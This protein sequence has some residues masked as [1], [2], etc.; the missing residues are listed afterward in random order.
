[1]D[2]QKNSAS[3]C[4]GQK[5]GRRNGSFL[6]I[7]RTWN[8]TP[9]EKWFE[10]RSGLP[11]SLTSLYKVRLYKFV[12][13]W[14]NCHPKGSNPR[15]CAAE[16]RIQ[17][18]KFVLVKFVPLTLSLA[19]S[20]SDPVEGIESA[21]FSFCVVMKYDDGKRQFSPYVRQETVTNL[22]FFFSFR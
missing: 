8:S 17:R 15:K 4:C 5:F 14:N 3:H 11:E 10:I 22:L 1:M 20:T 6:M 7:I 12:L 9:N 18:P 16:Y 13:L 19:K 2:A 21:F